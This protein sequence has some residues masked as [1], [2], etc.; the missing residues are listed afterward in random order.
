MSLLQEAIDAYDA[1]TR[2]VEHLEYDSRSSSSNYK[3]KKEG[4]ETREK[5]HGESVEAKKL[6]EDWNI[7]EESQAEIYKIDMDHANKV[8][9]MQEDKTEPAEVQKVVDVV[10]TAKLITEVVTATSETIT[11][12]SAIMT[13]AEAQV[14]TAINA[15]LSAAPASV[16]AA[17]SRRRKVVIIRDPE[18]ESGTSTI[19]PAKTKSKD[20]GGVGDGMDCSSA[21][22]GTS[23]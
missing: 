15:T 10:T 11:A 12:A 22:V 6:A 9:N 4:E 5:E 21:I 16:A 23:P 8:L 17:P 13:T 20:K 14:P 18:E 19:I 7:L 2:R 1:L 3:D